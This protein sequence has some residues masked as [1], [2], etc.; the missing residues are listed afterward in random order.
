MQY[1]ILITDN[2]ITGNNR[3]YHKGRRFALLEYLFHKTMS[4]ATSLAPTE[5]D[6][7][8]FNNRDVT[9]ATVWLNVFQNGRGKPSEVV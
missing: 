9:L 4:S 7:L 8:K 2:T 5:C 3:V 1:S 6:A